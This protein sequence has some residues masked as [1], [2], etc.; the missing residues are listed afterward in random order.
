M[1]QETKKDVTS[2]KVIKKNKSSKSKSTIKLKKEEQS[3][4]DAI[5]AKDDNLPESFKTVLSTIPSKVKTKNIDVNTIEE[6]H[7]SLRTGINHLTE[8][9][10][11]S[12]NSFTKIEDM[13]YTLPTYKENKSI[14]ENIQILYD[15]YQAA[16]EDFN[17][18]KT[19]VKSNHYYIEKNSLIENLK[20]INTLTL[21]DN[22]LS[23]ELSISLFNYKNT[24]EKLQTKYD[25]SL[26]T[27]NET[28]DE[29]L[30]TIK[31]LETNLTKE[32]ESSKLYKEESVNRY[33]SYLEQISRNED[34]CKTKDKLIEDSQAL[35][36]EIRNNLKESIKQNNNLERLKMEYN[37]KSCLYRLFHKF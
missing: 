24:F 33:N 16:L 19:F 3:L 15:K 9:E 1:K 36:S 10:M 12:I 5:V 7:N 29:F 20:R 21:E 27:Y 4:V 34:L 14:E 23:K 2:E 22:R 13:I 28:K 8:I 32:K 18:I 30:V 35:V 6:K 37:S 26:E 25:K 17:K 31:D 11:D